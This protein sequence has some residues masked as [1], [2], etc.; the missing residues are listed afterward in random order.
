MALQEQQ[1][2]QQQWSPRF[3][4][5]QTRKLVKAYE[6]NPNIL[7]VEELR[8][9]ASYHNVPFYEG[10]FSLFDAV[11]QLGGGFFEG[12]TTFSVADP[13]DNEYEAVARSLGHLI[14]FAPGILSGPLR[15]MGTATKATSLINA[16]K[17]IQGAKGAPLYIAEK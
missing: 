5:A 13:P 17:A 12:F 6:K 16:A 2:A 9:H 7:P 15:W 3:D 4:N 11:R 14:G 1:L 10:D 8:Q